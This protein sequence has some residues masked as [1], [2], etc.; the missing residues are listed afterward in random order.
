[1]AIKE[2]IDQVQIAGATASGAHGKFTCQLR[3]R[4]GCKGRDFFVPDGNPFNLAAHA[5]RFGDAI[6]RIPNQPINTLNFG[7]FQR[8]NYSIRNIGHLSSPIV[9]RIESSPN[10]AVGRLPGLGPQAT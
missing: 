1:M 10:P 3:L 6:E 8:L 2:P 4:A 7:G 5:H 9:R